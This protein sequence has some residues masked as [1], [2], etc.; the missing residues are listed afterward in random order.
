MTILK[1]ALQCAA[2]LS[3]SVATPAAAATIIVNFGST[4]A[5]PANNNFATQLG[6][7]GLTQYASSGASLSLSGPARI[8]FHFMG[9]ESRFDDTFT[10]LAD[11]I[12]DASTLTENSAFVSWAERYM[13]RGTYETGGDLAGLLNFTTSGAD[14]QGAAIG[15]Q[16]FG[17]FLGPN[18]VSGDAYTTLFL[19]YD[20]QR[21]VQTPPDDNHDDFMIRM[22]VSPVPEPATWA[23]M[24]GGFGLVGTAMRRRSQIRIA[25]A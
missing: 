6:N 22:T 8:T 11:S 16:G 7:L 15:D 19:G 20:D 21:S 5:I 14:G 4:D 18:A 9:S 1:A 24:I 13:G 10:F 2:L 25:L 12:D 3:A 23:L 17:I